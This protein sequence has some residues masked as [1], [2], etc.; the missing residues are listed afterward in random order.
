MTFPTTILSSSQPPAYPVVAGIP[1]CNHDTI[2]ARFSRRLRAD[3]GDEVFNSWFGRLDLDTIAEGVALFSV[4]TKFLKSWIESHYLDRM[5]EILVAEDD[6]IRAISIGVR[7]SARVPAPVVSAQKKPEE[8]KVVLLTPSAPARVDAAGADLTG[9]SLDRRL[10]FET[11]LVGS[12]NQLAHSAALRAASIDVDDPP[13]FNP[14]YVHGAVGLG[15]THLLQAVAAAAS[16]AGRRAI[17]F[18][19][20]RFMYGFAY[21]MKSRTM[22]EFK[23]RLRD[24]DILVID[25]ARF[26]QGKAIQ[27]EFEHTINAMMAAGKQIVVGADRPA[28]DLECLENRVRSRLAGGLCAEVRCLDKT[29]R[30]DLLRARVAAAREIYPA[31]D[32]PSSVIDHIASVIQTNG[33]D[34][35]GA[36]NRLLAHA[37][38]VREPL[39]VETASV[40]ISDLVRTREPRR[41]KIEEIQRLVAKHFNVSRDDILS[42]RRTAGV[43]RPRQIAMYLAKVMTLRSLPEIGRRFGGRDHTTVLHAIRRME[44]LRA[45]EK[46]LDEDITGLRLMLEAV[47]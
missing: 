11:Y 34:L 20:E 35:D 24:V 9:S 42:A 6:G 46:P 40:A 16:A 23:D 1:V 26:L 19:A 15:K 38:L 2:W 25:D 22:A 36:V 12:S 44:E 28:I 21:A 37:S 33:R 29:L 39:T 5:A 10:T 41:V 30:V 4:P 7:T 43:V 14:L 27:F 3:V 32:V 31:F 8:G 17:Y 45:I 18:T 13:I 47:Q